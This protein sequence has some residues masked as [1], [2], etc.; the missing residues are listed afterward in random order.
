LRGGSRNAPRRAAAYALGAA[1]FAGG[2]LLT[3]ALTLPGETVL[4]LV[5]SRLE[6]R[7]VRLS[8][9]SARLV[10]PLGIRIEDATVSFPGAP[11]IELDAITASWEWTGLFRWLPSHL[12]VSRGNAAADIRLSPAFWSPSRGSV[13]VTGFS[14]EEIPVFPAREAGLSVRRAE[15]SWRGSG[16]GFSATGSGEFEF[17]RFPVP[18]PESP[19]REARIDN[20]TL[21]F[22]ARGNMLH[23]PRLLGSYEGSRVEGTGEIARFLSPERATVVFHLSIR[24]PHEGRV[25]V[26]FDM[27]AKNA[28]NANLRIVGSLDAPKAEIQLF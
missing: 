5:A 10:F 3:V 27:L 28:K 22:V 13:V 14:S 2:F 19:I 17:L 12:S 18:S 16:P 6:A 9:G 4:G 26:L 15:A 23:V 24:N 20:A 21:S 8:A 25:G 7:G 11:P 1:L